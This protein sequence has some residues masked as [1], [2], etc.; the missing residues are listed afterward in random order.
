MT[1]VSALSA[2]N[3]S[4]SELSPRFACEADM[5]EPLVTG[6]GR[7]MRRL[8]APF[9][10][11]QTLKGIVDVLFARI[12]VVVLDARQRAGVPAV[13]DPASL[14]ALLA[15]RH[16]SHAR[17]AFDEVAAQVSTSRDHLRRRVLPRLRE[18]GWV[19]RTGADWS[20]EHPYSAPVT[21]MTAIELKRSD[22]RRALWQA[23]SY[24][25]FAQASYVALDHSRTSD[26]QD[27]YPAFRFNRVGL[28][29][30]N[31]QCAGAVVTRP[32]VAR[33]A[34]ARTLS[35]LV[36]AERVAALAVQGRRSGEPRTVFG[37]TLSTTSGRDLRYDD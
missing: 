29:T 23:A 37:R 4:D 20:L 33:K 35:H 10:E 27:M 28:L 5:V 36:V 14:A 1:T 12:D 16:T 30:I 6:V 19:S 21:T 9:F 25:D 2:T 18:M 24:L 3:G 34:R 8:G 26:V 22:W 7:V 11:V 13:T 17:V 32:I 31:N 15:L